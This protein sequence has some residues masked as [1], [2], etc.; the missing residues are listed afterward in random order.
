MKIVTCVNKLPDD[1]GLT[2]SVTR[3]RKYL[4]RARPDCQFFEV[5]HEPGNYGY[6]YNELTRLHRQHRLDLI[7]A[8]F[9]GTGA[10]FEA[11]YFANVH[12]IPV[13]ISL[14][15]NDIHGQEFNPST[16]YHL[17]YSITNADHITALSN[18]ILN[19]AMML[20]KRS[21]SG[22]EFI[23]S[24]EVIY[25]SFDPEAYNHPAR[26]DPPDTR[27]F[28]NFPTVEQRE[29]WGTIV[30]GA[31]ANWY[32]PI[33]GLYQLV[34]AFAGVV[35][36]RGLSDP[37]LFIMG[38]IKGA[39]VSKLHREITDGLPATVTNRISYAGKIESGEVLRFMSLC[40]VG[41]VPS[42]WDACPMTAIEWIA[43]AGK[44]IVTG[45]L[46][47]NELFSHQYQTPTGDYREL[48]KKM[49]QVRDDLQKWPETMRQTTE[50]LAV[51]MQLS[52]KPEKEAQQYLD[53]YEF[54]LS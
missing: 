35:D 13:I 14:R 39:E 16:A 50:E 23:P 17:V 21:T 52:R 36:E 32:S 29:T 27:P 9:G 2:R 40:D 25:N 12:K 44:P 28:T 18:D 4:R 38:E 51:K 53:R 8:F 6:T 47:A 7:H 54:L 19:R 31:V 41:V 26:N 46:G 49:L 34:K 24:G 43:G 5:N 20:V 10:G 11:V 42:Q 3:V 30:F 45:N 15:G 1:T 48:F 37:Y 22:R 33:K